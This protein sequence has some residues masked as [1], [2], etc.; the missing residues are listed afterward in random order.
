VADRTA[1]RLWWNEFASHEFRDLDP[2]ATIA[3]L[4]IAATEQHGPHLP[5]CVDAAINRGMLATL[6]E[7]L[8]ADIDIRILPVQEIGKSNEHIRS[9]GTLTLPPGV[10]IEAWTELGLSV[11]RTGLRKLVI[12]NSHGGN[13][14][15]M[16]IVARELRVR[17]NM[18]VVKCHWSRLGR[19]PGVYGERE[20]RYGIHAGDSETS[21]MLHFRPELVDMTRAQD[22]ASVVE[23]E[24]QRFTHLRATGPA[25]YAWLASDLNP[26]GAVGEAHLATAEKG[27]IT[28]AYYAGEFIK[29]LRD[30][31]L[32]DLP[33]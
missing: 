24:E 16:G 9:P 25:A 1:R 20:L 23:R 2:M 18:L 15:I 4:P 3:I 22:F 30:V 11:A 10:L 13:D 29:L 12:A 33:G 31:K 32:A 7:M 6:G 14:E 28:A 26:D 17:A 19:P 21:L 27:R 5:V 8:P